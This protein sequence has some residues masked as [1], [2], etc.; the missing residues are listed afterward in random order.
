MILTPRTEGLPPAP[1]AAMNLPEQRLGLL[2][3]V[4]DAMSLRIPDV[5]F[6]LVG[7]DELEPLWLGLSPSSS[8]KDR[9]NAV[10]DAIEAEWMQWRPSELQRG[11][12]AHDYVE[13]LS[14]DEYRRRIG[15][16]EY[17]LHTIED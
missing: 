12:R 11:V 13:F 17:D 10:L 15:P 3:C 9:E 2:C 16:Y 14:R 6:T 1:P 5:K 8:T 4:V 7:V